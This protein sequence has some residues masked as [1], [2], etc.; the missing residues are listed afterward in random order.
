MKSV[1]WQWEKR[2]RQFLKCKTKQ[3]KKKVY[4]MEKNNFK[5]VCWDKKRTALEEKFAHIEETHKR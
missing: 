5:R 3:K 4:T 1:N 2:I